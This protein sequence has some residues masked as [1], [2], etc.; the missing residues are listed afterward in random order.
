ME[1]QI[2]DANLQIGDLEEQ[3]EKLE[4]TVHELK[5][6]IS[7]LEEDNPKLSTE[8]AEI[9]TREIQQKLDLETTTRNRLEVSI[10]K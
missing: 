4:G 3:K 7:H 1:R 6:K 9:K 8:M 10:L 5:L 2:L